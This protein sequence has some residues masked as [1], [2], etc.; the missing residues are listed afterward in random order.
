MRN[1]DVGGARAPESTDSRPPRDQRQEQRPWISKYEPMPGSRLEGK[2]WFGVGYKAGERKC[3]IRPG[4]STKALDSEERPNARLRFGAHQRAQVAHTQ[5]CRAA[6]ALHIARSPES[7]V[8]CPATWNVPQ[9]LRAK[10]KLVRHTPLQMHTI[11]GG[12]D[13][14]GGRSPQEP[15]P[16]K[17][18]VAG[19]ILARGL[20]LFTITPRCGLCSPIDVVLLGKVSLYPL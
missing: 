14:G 9:R 6:R 12:A 15:R 3:V 1:R 20:R 7:E 2:W 10:R 8:G 19:S 13:V 11:A 18:T 5:F 4:A 16:R 17:R